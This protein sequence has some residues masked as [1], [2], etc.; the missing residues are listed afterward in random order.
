MLVTPSS[1]LTIRPRSAPIAMLGARQA[2]EGVVLVG[3]GSQCVMSVDEMHAIGRHLA[4]TRPDLAIEVGFLE[5]TD[6]PAGVA[7]DRLVER[8]ATTV[9]VLP[10][11]LFAAGH[12]KSDAPA[13]VLEGR[14]RHPGIT[15]LYGRPFGV[16]HALL[17]I[18]NDNIVESGG[19]GLPLLVIA[20]G[21][22]DPD[23]NGDAC[24][25]TRLLSEFSGA[26][27]GVTGF[28]GVTGPRVPEALEIAAKLGAE[29]VCAFA[30]FLCN[31]KLIERM[32]ADY[33]DFTDRTGVEVVDAGYFGPDPRLAPIIGLRFTEARGARVSMS[34]DVC[35][36][37]LPFPTLGD[38]VGQARGVGHSHLAEEHRHS[39]H[40][41]DHVHDHPHSHG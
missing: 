28:S 18:A 11:M 19:A 8:G 12:A 32:R 17:T 36:Y 31:G 3:H 14:A 2:D 5:M 39:D 38:R 33:R 21:T 27:F 40:A 25:A 4:A 6:P 9:T 26:P 16:D 35:S 1:R 15:L 29:K 13:I 37:R 7:L 20:R 10:L 22:S 23:A 34:C 24:K 41:N 30:W